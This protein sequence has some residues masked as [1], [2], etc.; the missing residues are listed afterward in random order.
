MEQLHGGRFVTRL[1]RVVGAMLLLL[2]LLIAQSI[3]TSRSQHEER[4]VVEAYSVARVLES[5]IANLVDKVRIALHTVAVERERRLAGGAGDDEATRA[6]IANLHV[7][8]RD[9][10][11]I[12]VADDAG[13]LVY[14]TEFA[15]AP[16]EDLGG[17][18]WFAKLRDG[19]DSNVLISAP[20]RD[21]A[22]GPLVVDII[23]RVEFPDGRFAGAVVAPVP[24][25]R[26][27][28]LL[29]A[30][31][32]GPG[33]S[34]AVRGEGLTLFARYPVLA[35]QD[36]AVPDALRDLVARGEVA[37]TFH[38]VSPLDGTDRLYSYRRVAAY[39]LHI[40][41]ARSTD[42]YL[43]HWRRDMGVVA[44][45]SS[46]LFAVSIGATLMVD[47]AWRRQRR[48]AHLLEKQAHTDPLTG[49][50]NRRHFMEVADAE[51]ARS[52]RYDTPLS[53]LM[54]DI[55][56]FKEVN[57]A[58]GHRA[59]DRVLQQLAR[60]CLEIL[61]EVDVAGRVGGEEF[62]IL[63]PE[64]EVEGAFEVA[65]RL[66]TAVAAAEVPREEGLPIR[67]TIS[68]GVAA[69]DAATN[70]DTL[71][72]QADDALYDAKHGGRNLVRRFGQRG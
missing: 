16:A 65:E 46:M 63:L 30:A 45:L 26:L 71:M 41:V 21:G 23:R 56:H 35:G 14:Q 28:T 4:A 39:P 49:L 29:A 38:A 5:D 58:H 17:Q 19:Y 40:T 1:W 70:L 55:D 10:L 25:E 68:I 64:T 12:R 24:A 2:S 7:N 66:R 54:I 62:A 11:G 36:G 52:R 61:R 9:V 50:A 6:Y 44:L 22:E 31:E 48:I 13:R 15:T 72:S 32:A 20:H 59:G 3:Q 37:G 42:E 27:V 69:M 67:V 33:G 43:G 47:R 8:V 53:M 18:P 34:I 57:D 51:L 60:T